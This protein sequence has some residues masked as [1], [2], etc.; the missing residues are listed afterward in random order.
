MFQFYSSIDDG[1]NN[2]VQQL[3]VLK[4]DLCFSA[5][6]FDIVPIT[7]RFLMYSQNSKW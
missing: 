6:C 1:E 2:C 4:E 7:R 5:K 3:C